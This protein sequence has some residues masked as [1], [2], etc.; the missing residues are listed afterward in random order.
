MIRKPEFHVDFN[1]W[2]FIYY[3]VSLSIPLRILQ[4]LS[5]FRETRFCLSYQLYATK[6]CSAFNEAVNIIMDV[7]VPSS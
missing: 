5:S 3:V 6:S 4:Y 2:T 1:F 7:E